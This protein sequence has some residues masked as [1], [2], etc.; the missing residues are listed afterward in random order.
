MFQR[1]NVLYVT[2]AVGAT[3]FDSDASQAKDFDPNGWELALVSTPTNN[4]TSSQERQLV[5][6]L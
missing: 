4:L 6:F 3:P 5:M 2:H 1:G